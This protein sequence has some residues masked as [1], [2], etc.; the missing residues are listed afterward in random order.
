MSAATKPAAR[1]ADGSS[2]AVAVLAALAAAGLFLF[3]AFTL[4]R[5]FNG[6]GS[7]LVHPGRV[8]DYTGFLS[9]TLPGFQWVT[10]AGWLVLLAALGVAAL[11]LARSRWLGLAGWVLLAVS[12]L[13][14][15]AFV[16]AVD[17]A[18]L[19]LLGGDNPL[20][21]RRLPFQKFGP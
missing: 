14:V 16:R 21:F 20:P 6:A 18:Q 8:M 19:P 7:L 17:V 4:S 9:P 2:I 10:L 3:P 15:F 13:H 12:V 1:R 11:A 5:S